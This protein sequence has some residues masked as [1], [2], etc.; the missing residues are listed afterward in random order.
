MVCHAGC[1]CFSDGTG[2]KPAASLS[3]IHVRT[4]AEPEICACGARTPPSTLPM[5]DP[6]GTH[7]LSLD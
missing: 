3:L 1:A 7:E 5:T 2:A 4:L 6:N